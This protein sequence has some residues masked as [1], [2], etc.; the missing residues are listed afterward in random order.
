MKKET[1]EEFAEE[2]QDFYKI[3][4]FDEHC[5]DGC[6]YNCT[7]GNT[8]L[9]ECLNKQET[10]EEAAD[11]KILLNERKGF[12]DGAKW[13]Q[14]Q[15]AKEFQDLKARLDIANESATKALKMIEDLEKLKKK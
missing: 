10:L 15:D 11:K 13:Q 4:D 5:D 9:A 6:K 2:L 7:K 8:Q 12:L 1:F 3:G 14:D